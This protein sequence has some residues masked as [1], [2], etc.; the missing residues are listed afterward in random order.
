MTIL[1]NKNFQLGIITTLIIFSYFCSISIGIS[2]DELF[3]INRGQ[4]RLKYIF[5]LGSYEVAYVQNEKYYPGFYSTIAAF[6]SNIMPKKYI[7]ETYHLINNTFS[8]LT[9]FGLY[10]LSK[11]LFNKN[12]AFISLVILFL[13][14]TFFGHMSMN[15]KDTI[16]ALSLVWTTLTLFRYLSYQK[17][18][19]KRIK[20]VIYAGFLIGLG[21]GVR[22]QFFALLIPLF[23]FVFI[24][25]ILNR[26]FSISIFLFDIFII[27]TISYFVMLLFWPHVHSNIF[28]EP[29]KNFIEQL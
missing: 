4:E 28:V 21:L 26:N 11:F 7:Y 5:S 8:I 24:Y 1:E 16:I 9:I 14:P 19:N 18:N 25:K 17:D 29:L 20:Y 3:E 6:I 12:V 15:P 22:M 10:R 27:I 13:N 23:I 2:W